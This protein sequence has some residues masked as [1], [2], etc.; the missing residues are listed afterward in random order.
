M[1]KV[2]LINPSYLRTAGNTQAGIA[3]PVFPILSLAA[4]GG[5]AKQRGHDARIV[6]LSY[7]AYD[8][9]VLRDLIRR[10]KPDVV[11]ITATTPLMNQARDIS[12]LVKEISPSIL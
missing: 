1:A 6:D 10:E 5:V 8:P 9:A 11:G 4:L 7:R 2:L 3:N 12:F